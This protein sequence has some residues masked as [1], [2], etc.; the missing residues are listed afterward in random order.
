ML[1]IAK[2]TPLRLAAVALAAATVTGVGAGSASAAT[3]PVVPLRQAGTGTTTQWYNC[4]PTSMVMAMLRLGITPKGYVSPTNYVTAVQNM[5]AA[6][7]PSTSHYPNPNGSN[8]SDVLDGL[9]AYG[10]TGT[11]THVNTAMSA[12]QQGKVAIVWGNEAATGWRELWGKNLK[13]GTTNVSHIVALVGYSGGKYEIL[14]P[15]SNATS[16]TPHW[17]T[18]SQLNIYSNGAGT[19][20]TNVVIN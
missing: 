20:P 8:P 7:S 3:G 19:G 18:A 6:M 9:R 16:N 1:H 10:K 4:G 5:R 15:L 17:V 13:A 12:A 11:I 14:D 2:K